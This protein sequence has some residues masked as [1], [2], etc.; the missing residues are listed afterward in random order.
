[1]EALDKSDQPLLDSRTQEHRM[2][3]NEF[4][5]VAHQVVDLL[6]EYFAHIEEKRV[7]PSAD[8]RLISGIFDEP[9][10]E[11]PSSMDEILS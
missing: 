11:K 10:P 2:D 5:S 3:P 4:R 7:F 6:A 1:L 9:I 8:P